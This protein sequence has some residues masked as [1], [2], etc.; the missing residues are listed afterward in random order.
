MNLKR[1]W[2]TENKKIVWAIPTWDPHKK[3]QVWTNDDWSKLYVYDHA[4]Y[5]ELDLTSV[6]TSEYWPV[7]KA[8]NDEMVGYYLTNVP[9]ELYNW[10]EVDEVTY[11]FKDYDGTVLK[12]GKVDDGETPTAPADPTREADA[13]YTY[14]FAGWNPTVGKITKK[15]TYTATYTATVNQYDVTIASEDTDKGTVDESTATVDYW[16]AISAEENVLTIGTGEDAVVVTATPETGYVFSS[17]WELPATVTED[18]SITATF[19]NTSWDMLT[20]TSNETNYIILFEDDGEWMSSVVVPKIFNSY[21]A[22][23]TYA[24]IYS[25]DEGPKEIHIHTNTLEDPEWVDLVYFIEPEEGYVDYIL[26]DGET[27]DGT[28]TNMYWTHTL[29]FHLTGLE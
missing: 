13:Q 29:T 17:W 20:L 26:L 8:L 1:L 25:P 21:T 28:Q 6:T 14:T 9:T 23:V 15:T 5:L 3:L 11:T 24:S 16:T 19:G 2:D 27:W 22:N 4:Q 10:D 12:T 18:L 7:W